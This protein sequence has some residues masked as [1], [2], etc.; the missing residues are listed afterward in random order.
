MVFC[1]AT[2]RYIV[3]YK[4]GDDLRQDQLVLQMFLL[5][6]RLLKRENL[7]LKLT[8]YRCVLRGVSAAPCRSCCV[9]AQR[10]NGECPVRQL[11][12]VRACIPR[13]LGIV[14]CSGCC[15]REQQM[16]WSSMCP[17]SDGA[18]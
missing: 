6:D 12:L 14:C 11:L 10:S 17:V 7:D 15:P 9:V 3:I 2:C 4:A 1:F 13:T 16:A 8:P 5:M 18:L